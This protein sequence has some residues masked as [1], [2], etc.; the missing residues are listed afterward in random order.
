M[1]DKLDPDTSLEEKMLF[2]DDDNINDD[3]YTSIPKEI[4]RLKTQMHDWPVEVLVKKIEDKD[5]ILRPQYQRDFVWERSRCSKLIESILL[6]VPLPPIYLAEEEDGLLSVIDGLQRLR[7]FHEFFAD[8]FRLIKLRGEGLSDL[9]GCTFSDLVQ[10]A[11]K[12]KRILR[13]GNIRTITIGKDSDPEIKY[14]IFERLNSGSQ[15]LNDQEIRNCIYHGK[16]N[17]LVMGTYNTEKEDYSKDGLRHNQHLQEIMNL[18]KPHKRYLDAEVIL[19]ILAVIDLNG[20]VKTKYKSSMKLLINHYMEENRDPE[21]DEINRLREVFNSTIEKVYTV[22]GKSSFRR[23]KGDQIEKSLN[24]SIMDCVCATFVKHDKGTLL[25]HKEQIL[26]LMDRMLNNNQSQPQHNG[27][28][29]LDSVTKWTSNK[30]VLEARL[31]I[32]DQCLTEILG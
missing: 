4:R 26:Q 7:T 24:R 23:Y 28:T 20:S 12:A 32:W 18:R 31:V 9:N 1:Q 21:E 15:K 10:K 3:E 30:S 2:E 27:Q 16:L 11:P 22:F 14:D 8:K 29:F 6:N 19:R 17:N 5:I 25:A 13:S